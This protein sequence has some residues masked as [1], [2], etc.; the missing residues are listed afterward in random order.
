MLL[1]QVI[2]RNR[3][4][5]YCIQAYIIF[6]SFQLYMISRKALPAMNI[7]YREKVVSLFTSEDNL[8]IVTRKK[9]SC[10]NNT[11]GK[12]EKKLPTYIHQCVELEV[13]KR[14]KECFLSY[15]YNNWILWF[16]SIEYSLEIPFW[17]QCVVFMR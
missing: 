12:V 17:I 13:I 15:L 14:A 2:L 3:L 7:N 10:S 9:V 6:T 11:W 8:Y 5:V 4:P 16:L 1:I